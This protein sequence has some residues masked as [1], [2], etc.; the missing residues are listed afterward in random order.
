MRTAYMLALVT[1]AGLTAFSPPASAQRTCN[2]NC[3]GPVC[4][5]QCV[6][7]DRDITVG[8]GY[9]DRDVIIER[10]GRYRE[11]D[12]EIRERSRPR[13]GVEVDR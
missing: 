1:A 8:R 12:V 13:F 9:R 5:R 2:E 7:R 10:R 11:P 4:S 3:V 6:D